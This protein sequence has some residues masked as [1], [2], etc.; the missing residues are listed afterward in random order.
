MG[1]DVFFARLYHSWERGANENMNGLIRQYVPK[2]S[3]FEYLT[4]EYIELIQ[5]KCFY[6]K[7]FFKSMVKASDMSLW[8]LKSTVR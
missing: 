8:T 6:F 4:D 3:S 2:G 5:N 1:I 7:S